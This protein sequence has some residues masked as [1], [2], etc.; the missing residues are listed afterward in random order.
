MTTTLVETAAPPIDT[1]DSTPWT[2]Y[3]I[4]FLAPAAI[5]YTIFSI[6]PLLD[7]IIFALYEQDSTGQRHFVGF[8]N[9]VTLLTD[10]RW[11]GPFWNAFKNNLVFFAIHMI[12]QN[13]IGLALAVL[14]SLPALV[15]RNVYRTLIFLP[16]MLS[17]VIIGFIWSLILSP[18]WGISRGALAALGLGQWFAPWLGIE[19]TALVAVS[20]ISVWQFVGIPMMLIYAALLN[21]PDDLVDAATVDGANQWHVFFYVKLPLILPTLGIVAIL[22]FVG[23]FN[24]F[25]LIYAIKGAIAGPNFATDILGT[26]F[27]RT[28][29]GYQLQPGS[30]TMGAT[31]A[32][33][34]LAII[35]VGVLLYL[36]GVQRRLQRHTL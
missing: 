29:F 17:V 23:N 7:T 6:Y 20:L 1:R 8:S 14:L 15:G 4:V 3:V 32:T 10:P 21:I 33:M 18:L 9:F 19:G 5:V 26:F 16:T 35:L 34:M 22:T 24:A 25:D 13:S 28:Y 11:A 36:F 2:S 12:V 27:Y 30:P 31:V